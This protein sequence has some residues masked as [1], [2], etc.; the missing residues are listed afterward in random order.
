LT[1]E[2]EAKGEE[3]LRVILDHLAGRLT[4]SQAA[5]DLGVSRKTFYEWLER[6]KGAMRT[7]LMDRPG[8]RP[9]KPVDPEK[10]QLLGELD[11]LEKER[12]GLGSRLRIQQAV[13]EVWAARESESSPSKKKRQ[14]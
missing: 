3:R 14:E 8:G 5:L 1:E 12:R 10:E 13:Q 9:P 4:A 2:L 11:S 7:A 6:G